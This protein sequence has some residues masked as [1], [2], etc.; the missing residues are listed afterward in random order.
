MTDEYV[1]IYQE[2]RDEPCGTFWAEH[3]DELVETLKDGTGKNYWTE[4]IT[5]EQ[6]EE[7]R[8]T[9]PSIPLSKRVEEILGMGEE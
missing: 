4:P 7:I 6:A 8:K 9:I 5:L 1:A 2:G 3:A